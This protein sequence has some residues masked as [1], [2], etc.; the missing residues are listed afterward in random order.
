MKI[1]FIVNTQFELYYLS[2]VAYLLKSK[3]RDLKAELLIRREIEEKITPEIQSLYSKINTFEVPKN[4]P[5]L[6]RDL[7]KTTLNFWDNIRQSI[8]FKNYLKNFDFD[9]DIICISSFR[10]YFANILTKHVPSR[11]RLVALRMADSTDE[12][13]SQKTTNIFN[14]LKAL[15][16]NIK[17]FIFGHSLMEYRWNKDTGAMILNNFVHNPYHRTILITDHDFG[18]ESINYRLPPPFIALR[19]LYEPLKENKKPAI[20]VAGERTSLYETWDK[21]SKRY[22]QFLDYLREN[23]EE[24]DLYFKGRAKVTEFEKLNLKGFKIVKGKVPLEEVCLKKRFDKVISIKST[25]S[26]IGAYFGYNSYL[27]YPM[28]NLPKNSLEIVEHYFR[29]MSSI[30]RVKSMSDLLRKP[31]PTFS[32]QTENLADQYYQAIVK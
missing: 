18:K 7:I 6:N 32:L 31:A 13:L 25:C 27:L 2:S 3:E 20:L 22:N 16:L 29:D 28:F 24:Y 19:E 10:E 26:K 30:V 15:Y 21:D 12:L 17:N 9:I 8:Q 4:F 11:V 14:S 5:K 23:F 1:L